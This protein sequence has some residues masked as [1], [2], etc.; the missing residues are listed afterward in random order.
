MP[1]YE[2]EA[3]D[4]DKACPHCRAGFEVV[5]P[6]GHGPLAACPECGR[7]VRKVIS[8]VRVQ[9]RGGNEKDAQVM[10]Q[11]RSYEKDGM[12]SHAAELADSHAASTKDSLL[13]ERAM[14]NYKKA[15]ADPD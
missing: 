11:I 1:I 13:Q 5:H 4:A 10:N 8:P 6:A 2:Y 15:G 9:I 14:N 3:V 7:S 12:W